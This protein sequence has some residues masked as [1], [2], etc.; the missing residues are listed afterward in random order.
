MFGRN[1]KGSK[2]TNVESAL[3]SKERKIS[4]DIQIHIGIEDKEEPAVRTVFVGDDK[5]KNFKV[6]P[7]S[8]EGK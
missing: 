3:V 6:I 8:T 1:K 2:E 7:P 4:F 5:H